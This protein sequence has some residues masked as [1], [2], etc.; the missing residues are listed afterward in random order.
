MILKPESSLNALLLLLN[1]LVLSKA[2]CFPVLLKLWCMGT[3][4]TVGTSRNREVCCNLIN[5]YFQE[6]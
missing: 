5:L 2:S 3:K 1:A 6:L 4:V